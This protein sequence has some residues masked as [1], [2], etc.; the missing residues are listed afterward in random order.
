[1]RLEA[2]EHTPL[3]L[4]WIA[5]LSS[6]LITLIFAAI[7]LI[8]PVTGFYELYKGAFGSKNSIA[9]TGATATPLI[10]TGLAAAI[11]FRARFWNIGAE[12]QLYI[13]ALAATYFGTGLVVFSPLVMVPFL[14][15]TGFLF[16]AL[17]LLPMVLL[18]QFLKVD[19]VVTTLLMNFV[20]ILLVS[21]LLEGPWKDPYSLGWCKRH[22]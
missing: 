16:G 12:G 14:L 13:G 8:R 7:L 1:M 3:W 5:I 15:L 2:R 4:P 17:A 9:E 10:F 11:A 18:R 21:Y 22:R 19:E 6:G 20:I